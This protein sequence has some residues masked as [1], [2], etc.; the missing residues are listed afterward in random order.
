MSSARLVSLV[1]PG[2]VGK[3]RLAIRMAADLA[4]GLPDGVW[5]VELADLRDP[6]LVGSAVLAALDLRDQAV[7]EPAALIRSYL[8]DRELLLVLENCEHLLDAAARLA[9]DVLRAA[10]GVRVIATSREPLS[11]AGEHVLPVPPPGTRE[12]LDRVRQNEAVR[13]FTEQAAASG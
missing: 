12:P 9:G 1:G 10:P 6:A 5:L 13:L 7:T 8:A 2:G 11:V 4:R 3:T